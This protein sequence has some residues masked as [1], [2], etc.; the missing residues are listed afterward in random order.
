[1]R[2]IHRPPGGEAAQM[3]HIVVVFLRWREAADDPVEWTGRVLSN[4]ER[5]ASEKLPRMRSLFGVPRYKHRLWSCR[6]T[7]GED[8]ESFAPE[9]VGEV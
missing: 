9:H 2:T 5:W 6:E 1:M 8:E 4:L 3:H 7:S